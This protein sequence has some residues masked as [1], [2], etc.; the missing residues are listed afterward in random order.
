MLICVMFIAGISTSSVRKYVI[1][2]IKA[3][4]RKVCFFQGDGMSLYFT[5]LMMC[6]FIL[7]RPQEPEDYIEKDF[8]EMTTHGCVCGVK[9]QSQSF[10]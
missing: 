9:L 2:T 6:V 1:T 5:S 3:N 4:G 8:K 10:L 7:D